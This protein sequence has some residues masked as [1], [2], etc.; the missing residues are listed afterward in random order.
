VNEWKLYRH[1]T[2]EAKHAKWSN[3]VVWARE[4]GAGLYWV[5]LGARGTDDWDAAVEIRNPRNWAGFGSEADD[6]AL[7]PPERCPKTDPY[8]REAFY[9]LYE[10]VKS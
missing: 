3:C 9:R 7:P 10:E 2:A 4:M 5:T 1:K 6:E 8:P